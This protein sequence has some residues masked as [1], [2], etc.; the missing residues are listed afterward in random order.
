[1]SNKE[2]GFI[3]KEVTLGFGKGFYDSHQKGFSELRDLDSR[4][5]MGDFKNLYHGGSNERLMPT[6]KELED[7]NFM[8][9]LWGYIQT[10]SKCN[11][12]DGFRY[13]STKDICPT[14]IAK[15]IMNLSK[16]ENS[17]IYINKLVSRPT[18]TKGI[19]YLKDNGYIL[20]KVDGSVVFTEYKG[21]YYRLKNE[22]VF[23][24]Y[25]LLENEFL[26]TL[27]STLSQ[28]VIRVYLLYYGFNTKEKVGQCYL[29]QDEIL[30]RI[31]LSNSGKNYKKLRYI[32]AVLRAMGLIE[33]K[34]RI[35]RDVTG[36]EI[37]RKLIT[38]APYYFDTKLFIEIQSG[39][40][41]DTNR[42]ETTIEYIAV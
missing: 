7:R 12:M 14:K 22:D 1:M 2:T 17:D 11:H 10:K 27:I 5:E 39:L 32:N 20:E 21:T 23:N 34:Y 30:A 33:Q 8:I 37:N 9:G 25:T 38:T 41:L 31:G 26:K 15:H 35:E 40:L 16:E 3:G 29:N 6:R 19:K 36:R 4:S 18:I 13:V 28:D 42:K 24:Y